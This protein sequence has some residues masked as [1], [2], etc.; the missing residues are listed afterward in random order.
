MGGPELILEGC[1]G[2]GL[3][4]FVRSIDEQRFTFHMICHTRWH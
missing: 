3:S 2:A 1:G 4:S